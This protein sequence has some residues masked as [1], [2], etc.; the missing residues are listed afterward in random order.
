MANAR[1]H[2]LLALVAAP[3]GQ[4]HGLDPCSN[5]ELIGAL[6]RAGGRGHRRLQW[7]AL[8]SNTAACGWYAGDVIQAARKDEIVMW[9]LEV[10]GIRRLLPQ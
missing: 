1:M 10:S 4:A 9:R 6:R 8:V 2:F 5:G 3:L 7:E